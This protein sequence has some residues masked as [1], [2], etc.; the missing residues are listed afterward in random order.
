MDG[1]SFEENEG[2]WTIRYALALS[3]YHDVNLLNE[4]DLIAKIHERFGE[5]EKVDL[6]QLSDGAVASEL[7]VSAFR[8][9]PMSQ[10]E[11]RNYRTFAIELLRTGT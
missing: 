4:V 2:R 6:L 9:Y 7:V 5:R 11:Q 10:S 1:F 8:M 3:S